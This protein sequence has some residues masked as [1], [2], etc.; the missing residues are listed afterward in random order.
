MN[1]RI[2]KALACAMPGET[3]FL[4]MPVIRPAALRLVCVGLALL[5]AAAAAKAGELGIRFGSSA[6]SL[7]LALA[8]M[9]GES[10]GKCFDFDMPLPKPA[11]A[12]HAKG[13][14]FAGPF[15]S[16]RDLKRDFGAKGDGT[17]DDTDAFQAALSSLSDGSK[18]SPVLFVPAGTYLIKRTISVRAARA[19]SVIGEH[20]AR[21]V[22]KWAGP[23]GGTLFH[24]NAVAYSRFNRMTFDGAGA[25]GIVVDQ[26]AMPNTPGGQFDTGNE[27]ADD[28]FENGRIG[29]RAGEFGGAAESVVLRSRFENNE[30]GIALR[31][32]NALDWW[33]WHSYFVKNFVGISNT[34]ANG[35]GAGNFHAYNNVFLSSGHADLQLLNTGTFN[36]RDN[37]SKNSQKFLEELFYYTNAAVTTLQRNTIIT[38]AGNNCQGCA[39][40]QGNMGPTVLT[41]NLFVRPPDAKGPAVLIAAL[42]PP[43]CLS[44]HNTFT[45]PQT[46]GCYSLQN[47]KGRFA[48]VDDIVTDPAKISQTA[49]PPPEPPAHVDRKIFEVR[50]PAGAEAIQTAVDGAAQYCDQRPIVHLPFGTYG[51]I[52]SVTVPANCDI[53][54][55]GDG[56][57]TALKWVGARNQAALI[58]NGPSRAILRDFYVNAGLGIGIAVANADQEGARIYMQQVQ[59]MRS[60][61]ANLLVDQLDNAL[62]ESDNFQLAL[63]SDSQSG[64]GIA[65]KAVGGPKAQKGLTTFGRVNLLAGSGGTN[66]LS[67]DVSGG[68]KVVVRDAWFEGIKPFAYGRVTDNSVVTFE[69]SRVAS[70]GWSEPTAISAIALDKTSCPVSVL[71]SSLD[72]D[73]KVADESGSP[74]AV[75]GNNFGFARRYLTS[76]NAGAAT[77]AF[78]R[79]YS[80]ES[81]SVPITENYAMPTPERLRMAFAQSRATRPDAIEDLAPGLTDLRL[82]RVSVE[83]GTIGIRLSR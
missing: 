48:T 82:Y 52:R 35:G 45:G 81:G 15:P 43:D 23:H 77:F 83:L 16:W 40:Y 67:F 71:S 56:E 24:I 73:V 46:V 51:L 36:F 50:P 7:P 9:P 58:L 80:K 8:Q 79:Y 10:K 41:D 53:Q 31:N 63:T 11:R 22:L 75:I 69:G 42:N 59:L 68:A 65:F 28:V 26:S 55:I 30:Y 78:N 49:P 5:P 4:K 29:I 6:P 61:V 70:S 64:K 66:D 76:G 62:V 34:L 14:G 1:D 2:S 44:I 60:S 27:Y 12:P 33:V 38:A 18:T 25:A 17:T 37:F 54:I 72:A 74:V 19:I 21:V 32:F 3:V 47:G 39:V 57:R 20:P 13:E